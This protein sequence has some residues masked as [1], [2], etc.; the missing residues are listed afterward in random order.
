MLPVQPPVERFVT[1]FEVGIWQMQTDNPD[2]RGCLT[3]AVKFFGVGAAIRTS[4]M[5]IDI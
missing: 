1:D 2:I 3:I 4:G 5:V